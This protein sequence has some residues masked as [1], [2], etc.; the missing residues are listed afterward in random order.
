MCTNFQQGT[1]CRPRA[2]NVHFP[3]VTPFR[4]DQRGPAFFVGGR[5]ALESAYRRRYSVRMS[6]TTATDTLAHRLRSRLLLLGISQAEL[7]R[8]SG[9]SEMF[10]S[11]VLRGTHEPSARRLYSLAQTLGTTVDELLAE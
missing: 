2:T 8:R 10:V 3:R 4:P 6:T 9:L 7:A 11:R 1:D 5:L